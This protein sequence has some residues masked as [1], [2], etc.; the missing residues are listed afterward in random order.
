TWITAALGAVLIAVGVWLTLHGHGGLSKDEQVVVNLMIEHAEQLAS[1]GNLVTPPD[2]NV[3]AYVQKVLQRDAENQRAQALIERIGNA[4]ADQAKQ[5]MAAGKLE[6]AADL[7]NQAMLVHPD[8]AAL[9]ALA[10][11]IAKS[12]KSAQNK[13]Q[14]AKLVERAE[15]ARVAN[16][17]FG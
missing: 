7:D 5:A 11:D 3:F 16:R 6:E 13:Q 1:A 8:D 4:L 10:A 9:R 14:I 17:P 12:R 2:E 15:A